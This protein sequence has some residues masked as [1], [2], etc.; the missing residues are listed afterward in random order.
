VR[1]GQRLGHDP[2]PAWPEH[3]DDA[4]ADLGEGRRR[5]I[6]VED[7]RGEGCA[8]IDPTPVTGPDDGLHAGSCRS[9]SATPSGA[10]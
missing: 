1:G 10:T 6:V 4:Q 7:P 8:P 5:L 2:A 9:T 3:P